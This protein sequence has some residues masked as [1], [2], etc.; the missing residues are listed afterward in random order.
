MLAIPFNLWYDPC[1]THSTSR[2]PGTGQQPCFSPWRSSLPALRGS[3]AVGW[4]HYLLRPCC[5]LIINLAQTGPSLAIF[6]MLDVCCEI[7]FFPCFVAVLD[8]WHDFSQ[9]FQAN[10]GTKH[11]KLEWFVHVKSFWSSL[12]QLE[13]FCDLDHK[14]ARCQG[15]I[16][17]FWSLQKTPKH[18]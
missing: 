5:C 6:S 13:R 7:F 9:N 12:E 1:L 16:F 17:V 3:L 11:G 10:S 8:F 4:E 2:K 14:L 18:D 15:K